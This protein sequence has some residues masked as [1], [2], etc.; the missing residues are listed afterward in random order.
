MPILYYL[1][2]ALSKSGVFSF[3]YSVIYSFQFSVIFY[4]PLWLK[5]IFISYE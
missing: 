4:V 5:D 2:V 1:G 3:Q